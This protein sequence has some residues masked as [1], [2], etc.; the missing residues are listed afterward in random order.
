MVENAEGVTKDCLEA[1]AF[2]AQ[3]PDGHTEVRLSREPLYDP[4]RD[5]ILA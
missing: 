4:K 2:T 1:G 3:M 5:R